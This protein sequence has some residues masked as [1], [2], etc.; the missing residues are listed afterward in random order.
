MKLTADR[1]PTMNYCADTGVEIASFNAK[2]NANA[3]ASNCNSLRHK[4]K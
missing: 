2:F 1:F 3:V 4:G